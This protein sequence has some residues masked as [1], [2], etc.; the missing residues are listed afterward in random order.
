MTNQA[1]NISKEQIIF[2]K[3]VRIRENRYKVIIIELKQY[4]CVQLF[5]YNKPLNILKKLIIAYKDLM[6]YAKRQNIQQLLNQT[7]LTE[8]FKK[9]IQQM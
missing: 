6:S 9:I 8:F 1:L 7:Q 2:Q 4:D 3:Y 5:L